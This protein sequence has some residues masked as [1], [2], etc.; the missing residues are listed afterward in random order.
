VTV[1]STAG[2]QALWRGLPLRAFGT[3]VYAQHSSPRPPAPTPAPTATT[4]I[5]SWKP[6]RWWAA[7][8]PRGGGAP[9]CDRWWT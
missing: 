8:T 5:S 2:Q 9:C 4:G 7:S 1:N 6:R 3:A